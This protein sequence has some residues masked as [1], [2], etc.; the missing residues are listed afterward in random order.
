MSQNLGDMAETFF[1][2]SL[3]AAPEIGGI[4]FDRVAHNMIVGSKSRR[5]EFDIVLTNGA[6]IAIVEVKLKAHVK[7][8]NQIDSQIKRYRELFP[9]H[10]D[11]AIYGGIASLTMP[12]D[13]LAEARAQ[14]YFVLEQIGNVMSSATEGMRAH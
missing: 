12:R 10:K 13:V 7:D 9:E 6:T 2:N 3:V 11:Y 14:G 1:Y 5:S 8:L 4:S